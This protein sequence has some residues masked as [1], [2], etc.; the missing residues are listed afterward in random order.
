MIM[1]IRICKNVIIMK[2]I[3]FILSF[4]FYSY[5]LAQDK[6]LEKQTIK[7]ISMQLTKYQDTLKGDM[8]VE[9]EQ[10]FNKEQSDEIAKAIIM[11]RKMI[12]ELEAEKQELIEVN[13]K[14]RN[15]C[16]IKVEELNQK[17]E[18]LLLLIEKLSQL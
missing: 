11:Y 16:E 17:I 2:I 5:I 10:Q 7:E 6:S 15:N 18:K 4:L 3:A 14:K 13:Q 9:K 1:R 12:T 8:I